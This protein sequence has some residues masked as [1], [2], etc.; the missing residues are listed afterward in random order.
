MPLDCA[1][2]APAA[3]TVASRERFMAAGAGAGVSPA[4]AGDASLAGAAG[5]TGA[6]VGGVAAVSNVCDGSLVLLVVLRDLLL[7][8]NVL[9]SCCLLDTPA[10]G[11]TPP[12]PA[13]PT[14]TRRRD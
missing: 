2:T 10:A 5:A 7:G 12:A 1:A 4:D 9:L 11:G 13:A 3:G 14:N 6:R 8:V